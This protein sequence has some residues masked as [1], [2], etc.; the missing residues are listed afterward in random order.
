MLF[1]IWT[2]GSLVPREW[3]SFHINLILGL[4]GFHKIFW[5]TT[6]KCENKFSEINLCMTYYVYSNFVTWNLRGLLRY[7]LLQTQCLGSSYYHIMAQ[8]TLNQSNCRIIWDAL[9]DLAPFKKHEITW[10]YNLKNM[11][12]THGRVLFLTNL[13][14]LPCSFIKSNIPP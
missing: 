1:Y 4:K 3:S 13:K 11:K 5:G 14:A 12:N 8:N 10:N 7:F 2:S 6:K 9:R